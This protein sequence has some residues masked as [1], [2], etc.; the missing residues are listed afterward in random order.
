MKAG[1][2]ALVI[3]DEKQI[4]RLLRMALE[5]ADHQVFEAE[6]G[7]AGLSEIVH[8]RP[9]VVL[10]DLGLPDMEGIKVLRRLREW[11]RVP[12]L[13]LSVR[14]D[15]EE[16]VAALDAGADDYVTKPFDTAELL[17]RVRVIQRRSI[18]ET[19]EPVFESGPLKV[20]LSARQVTLNGAEVRLTPTEYALLRALVQHCGKVITHRQLLR[21]VWGEKAESQ[22]QYLRVYIT[23][24]RKKLESGADAPQLIRTEVGIGYRLSTDL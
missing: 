22:A 24:L 13:I 7:Q 2:V 23:H 6:T 17:A 10:L 11:T 5:G 19:G 1:H 18:V 20:D 12:V 14:D 21:T 4:R 3:E 15:P 16:K 9:D 8:R